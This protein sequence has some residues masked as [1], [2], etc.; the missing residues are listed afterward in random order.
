MDD[1]LI[2]SKKEME[3][4]MGVSFRHIGSAN[5][6]IIFTDHPSKV[7]I[8]ELAAQQIHKSAEEIG[9]FLNHI[10]SCESDCAT[11]FNEAKSNYINNIF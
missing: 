6:N 7:Q 2:Q 4:A 10:M 11:R 9:F 5:K 3:K 8:E 1:L